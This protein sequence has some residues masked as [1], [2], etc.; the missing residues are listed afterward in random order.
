M[1]KEKKNELLEIWA[2]CDAV[3]KSTEYMIARMED[4]VDDED[5][6]AVQFIFETSEEDRS[7]WYDSNPDWHI[8]Y[9]DIK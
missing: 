7:N 2:Y 5:F 1:T 6:D 8:K 9:P 3:D 4:A